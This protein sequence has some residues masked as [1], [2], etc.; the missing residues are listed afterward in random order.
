MGYQ[1]FALVFAL[2][3]LAAITSASNIQPRSDWVHA[4]C[5]SE[6]TDPK[7]PRLL[8]AKR[9][10]SVTGLS[11]NTCAKFCTDYLIFGVENG[12]TVGQFRYAPRRN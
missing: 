4:G 7:V 8:S 3:Y 1:S 10:T 6:P 11:L 2:T 9:G 5:F 12:T